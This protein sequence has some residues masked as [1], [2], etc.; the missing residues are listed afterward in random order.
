MSLYASIGG[1]IGLLI[2]LKA[3]SADDA[4]GMPRLTPDDRCIGIS[5]FMLLGAAG[6]VIVWAIN[7]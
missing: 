7:Q 4:S 6:G 2:M 3:I 5:V 1:I